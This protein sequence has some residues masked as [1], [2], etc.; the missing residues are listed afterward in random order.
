MFRYAAVIAIAFGEG[1]LQLTGATAPDT[2]EAHTPQVWIAIAGFMILFSLAVIYFQQSNAGAG[3]HALDSGSMHS[4]SVILWLE[5]HPYLIL[6]LV[7]IGAGFESS[8]KAN[9]DSLHGN[10]KVPLYELYLLVMGVFANMALSTGMQF[11]NEEHRKLLI[12]FPFQGVVLFLVIPFGLSLTVLCCVCEPVKTYLLYHQLIIIA[13]ITCTYCYYHVFLAE[14]VFSIWAGT[15]PQ[16]DS[17]L[18]VDI[19][20]GEHTDGNSSNH[21]APSNGDTQAEHSS[22]LTVKV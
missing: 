11:L 3:L 4:A 18:S 14:Y 17:S 16:Q 10:G 1:I 2:W 15:A 6:S 7:C 21:N 19:P 5:L 9:S 13:C 20:L 22:D 8:F 12:H